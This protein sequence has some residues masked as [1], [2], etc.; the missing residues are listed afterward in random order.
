VGEIWAFGFRNPFRFSFDRKSGALIVGDVG[1]NDIEEVDVVVRGGNYGWNFKE[2]TLFFHING[3]DVGT[4]SRDRDPARVIPHRLIDPIAQ[5]DTH[6]EGHSVIGGFVYHGRGI[7]RLRGKYIFGDFALVFK[8]PTGPHDYGRLFSIN[9]GG[10]GGLRKISQLLV[11]PGGALSLALL[12]WGQD[13]R[14]ELYVLG[15]ISG[16]PFPDPA[17]GPTGRVLRLVPAPGAD[18]DKDDDDDD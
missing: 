15:N 3:N 6:H 10:K 18:D 16:L 11:L 9:P 14:G 2:G 8:F 4:A 13:A 1:Q 7:P 5:Y 17:V 12:G